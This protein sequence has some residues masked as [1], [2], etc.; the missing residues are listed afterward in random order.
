MKKFKIASLLLAICLGLA[1]LVGCGG[2]G[3]NPPTC[4]SHVDSDLNGECDVCSEPYCAEHVDVNGD[5]VCDICRDEIPKTSIQ[6]TIIIKD[7]DGEVVPNIEITLNQHGEVK[8]TKVSGAQGEITGE[9]SEAGKYI[10]IFTS[11]PENWYSVDNYSEITINKTS[12]TFELTVVDNTPNGS[13]EKPFPSENAE[14]G[15]AAKV[16][17]PAGQ[18]YNFT[19]KGAARYFV[20][21]NANATLIYKDVE[22]T[23]DENGVIKVLFEATE[24]TKP[25]L[26][27]I[28]NTANEDN[29]I[30]ITFEAIKGTQENPYAVSLEGEQTVYYSF[31]SE[32]NGILM[33]KSPNVENNIELYNTSSYVVSNTTNGKQTTYIPVKAGDN[34]RIAIGLI[35]D[36]EAAEISFTL[37]VSEGTEADPIKI[38]EPTSIRIN[39]GQ[40]YTFA[41]EITEN[42][43]VRSNV[44]VSVNGGEPVTEATIEGTTFTVANTTEENAEITV[45]ITAE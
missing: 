37:T 36:T 44:A 24:T 23:P 13:V 21:Y 27:Q 30:S 22:Y 28:V 18:T 1:V 26:F 6:Y 2:G 34:V 3:S 9:V 20:I 15:E 35:S 29:E 14:T 40:S 45:F 41:L 39:K 25:V 38:Y 17:F 7:E 31:V 12:N 33:V 11:L 43:S 16:V 19:T 42:V 5:S 4:E 10:V 8:D 32:I